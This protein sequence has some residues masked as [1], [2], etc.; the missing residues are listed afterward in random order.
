MAA[1]QV[2]AVRAIAAGV[3]EQ[4]GL[5]LEDVV[6][7]A[8]GRRR[9]VRIV[10]DLPAEQVGGV[11]ME[12]VAAASHAVSAALDDGDVLGAMPYTLEV[13]SPGA[14]RR[15]TERRHWARAR[16]RLVEV[17]LTDGST[18]EGRLSEVDDAGITLDTGETLA[19]TR[20]DGGRVR[21]DFGGGS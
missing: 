17:S 5:V 9:V 2:D 8:A 12:S 11:P 19:W 16:G 14:E 18:V 6:I 1:A 4:A 21:L 3:V 7:T 13:S 10:V 15:L 20:I